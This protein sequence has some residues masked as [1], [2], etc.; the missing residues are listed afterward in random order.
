MGSGSSVEMTGSDEDI[1]QRMLPLYYVK[2][3]VV[4]EEDVALAQNSWKMIIDDTSP[5]FLM[6]KGTEGFP[7]SCLTWF[8]DR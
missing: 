1:V 5:I 6:N 8:Y 4:S 2:D 7:S 3:A